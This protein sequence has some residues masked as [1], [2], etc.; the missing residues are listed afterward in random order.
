MSCYLGSK[1]S[2]A[3]SLRNDPNSS[4]AIPSELSFFT[5]VLG[6]ADFTFL[7][8]FLSLLKKF[9]KKITCLSAF[10]NLK[11]ITPIWKIQIF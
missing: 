9:I 7:V 10:I 8:E 6:R 5:L 3:Q 11:I 2:L 1:F 4:A